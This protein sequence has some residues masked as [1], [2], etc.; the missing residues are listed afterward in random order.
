MHNTDL[1][2]VPIGGEDGEG[3]AQSTQWAGVIDERC[4]YRDHRT[5]TLRRMVKLDKE[6]RRGGV[7][8]TD[9]RRACVSLQVT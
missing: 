6:A 3:C 9:A 5:W 7:Y 8:I 2:Q 1:E 4:A